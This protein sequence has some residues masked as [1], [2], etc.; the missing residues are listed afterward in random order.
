[1]KEKR[2]PSPLLCLLL[3]SI[4]A[5]V[6]LAAG[7]TARAD[8]ESLQ[9]PSAAAVADRSAMEQTEDWLADHFPL[10]SSLTAMH[11]RL[12]LL[13]GRREVDGVYVLADRLL[14]RQGTI[15]EKTVSLSAQ[16]VSDFATGF[17]GAVSLMLVPGAE[18]IESDLLP[19]PAAPA[20]QKTIIDRAYELTAEKVSTIDCYSML[21]ANRELYLYYR[22][23]SRWTSLGAYLAYSACGKQMGFTALSVDRMDVVHASH[24]FRG[25][26]C[27]RIQYNGV[28]PDTID[29]YSTPGNDSEVHLQIYDGQCWSGHTGL[30]FR[31]Y[32]EDDGY[33]VFLG[34]DQPVITIETDVRSA[35]RLLILKDS[36][37]NA[38]APFL[39]AHYS[40]I[41]L[42]DPAL[43]RKPLGELIDMD[44]YDQALICCSLSSF[45]EEDWAENL[46]RLGS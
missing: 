13:T 44:S 8:G 5:A 22:T 9:L 24:S 19:A 12:E 46:N 39:T 7:Q 30:Y 35:P 11:T 26:L 20:S 16:A 29:I 4:P 43:L 1:M 3:A 32:L 42:V 40:T 6:L 14:E 17:R 2:R 15:P 23:D 38:L 34:P 25:N 18:S 33:S 27:R 28:E 45:A 10:Q 41:T 21:S 31:E 36:W 37:A